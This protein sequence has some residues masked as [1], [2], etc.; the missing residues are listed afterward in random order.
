MLRKVITWVLILWAFLAV[1]TFVLW[2]SNDH[3][4]HNQPGITT[5]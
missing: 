1:I 3:S 4:A 2:A 5:H